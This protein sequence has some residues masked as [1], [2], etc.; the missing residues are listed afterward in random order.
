MEIG[1]KQITIRTVPVV[2]EAFDIILQELNVQRK[3]QDLLLLSRSSV[4]RHM[5]YEYI[6]K[7]KELI[8]G[9]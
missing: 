8:K 5:M 9:E 1:W 3:E 2:T 4:I 7:H 6:Q